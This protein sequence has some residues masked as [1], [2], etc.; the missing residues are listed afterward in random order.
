MDNNDG[1]VTLRAQLDLRAQKDALSK[2]GFD[3]GHVD[4]L[5]SPEALQTYEE[6]LEKTGSRNQPGLKLFGIK[7]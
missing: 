1:S 6:I 3:Q 7:N 5:S 2:W 4:I